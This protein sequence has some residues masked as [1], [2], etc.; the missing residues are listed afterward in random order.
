ML[1]VEHRS[2]YAEEI[3]SELHDLAQSKATPGMQ[4]YY[5]LQQ[6]SRIWALRRVLKDPATR[7]ME[8]LLRILCW[9]LSSE[10]RTWLVIGAVTT[11]ALI[12]VVAEQG[13][14]SALFAAPTAWI[15][16]QGARWL[17]KRLGLVVKEGNE[18]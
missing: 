17:R 5:A 8:T 11:A 6:L 14:G 3:R 1:P 2:R 9:V 7:R 12:D 13:W 15:F 18:E 10:R 16:H 4:L